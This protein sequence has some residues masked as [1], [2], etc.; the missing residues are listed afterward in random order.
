MGHFFAAPHAGRDHAVALGEQVVIISIHTPLAGCDHRAAIMRSAST[1]FQSTHPMRGATKH[2]LCTSGFTTISIHAPLAGCDEATGNGTGWF[3]LFQST[4]PLR[5]ATRPPCLPCPAARYFNPRTPCGVRRPGRPRSTARISRFQSTHPLRGATPILYFSFLWSLF[6]STHPL[7]GATTS[8]TS[9]L[10]S[11][12]FQF[13]H[14]LRGATAKP[15]T[16][17]V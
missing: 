8:T 3:A 5:G 13:T 12:L 14:P 7:R 9:P 16:N 6:Q 11:A 4:H 1:T 10:R 17:I 15:N 2:A